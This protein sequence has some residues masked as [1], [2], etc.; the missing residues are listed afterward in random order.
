MIPYYECVNMS[1]LDIK[2]AKE[3]NK[4]VEDYMATIRRV[5]QRNE[6]EKSAN[7]TKQA[8]LE[9]T[10][11]PIVKA[12]EKSTEA[13]TKQLAQTPTPKKK[14]TTWNEHSDQSAIEYYFKS[15]N[16]NNLDKYF[17]I[18]LIENGEY[19]LGIKK[20]MMDE[21]SNIYVDDNVYK[22]TPGLWRLIMVTHPVDFTDDDLKNYKDLMNRTEAKTNPNGVGNGRPTATAKWK[23]LEKILPEKKGE[24]GSGIFLPGDIKGL[25]TKLN[26]LLA[27]FRA[28]NESTRNEIIFILDELLR[29]KRMSRK[30]YTEINN[31]IT[32]NDCYNIKTSKTSH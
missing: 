7:L 11:S 8:E 16:K 22:G 20:I 30:E 31:Y 17:G 4:I 32:K 9:Q 29:R 6:D 19:V 21:K 14:Q 12:T 3:R 18:Q 5:Q 25:T 28:G 23:L 15:Y 26:L 1:F 2:D 24:E 10:F 13:I 27:E